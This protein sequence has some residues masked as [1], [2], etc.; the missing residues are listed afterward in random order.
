MFV[1]NMII[2]FSTKA[3]TEQVIF[4]LKSV[5]FWQKSSSLQHSCCSSF[6]ALIWT[7]VQ[8]WW[9]I[10]CRLRRLCQFGCRRHHHYYHH[11]HPRNHSLCQGF[12]CHTQHYMVL[13]LKLLWYDWWFMQNYYKIPQGE[14]IDKSDIIAM[15]LRLGRWCRWWRGWWR[16]LWS[17]SGRAAVVRQ[18]R[19]HLTSEAGDSAWHTLTSSS[20][21][22]LST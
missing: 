13:V 11:N 22:S 6:S 20:T 12:Y 9:A 19:P 7:S 10:S 3:S 16:W 5:E 14:E 8:W 2:A 1:I 15:P 21:S 18:S 17:R 4:K